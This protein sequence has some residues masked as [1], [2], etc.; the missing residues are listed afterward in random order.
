MLAVSLATFAG[1]GLLLASTGVFAIIA[2]SVSRRQREIGIR[3][4]LGA[5]PG[6]LEWLFLRASLRPASV[7]VAFGLFSAGALA[8]VLAK[9]LYGV[10]WWD[11]PTYLVTAALLLA[12]ASAAAYVPA[13]RAAAVNPV[14]ALRSE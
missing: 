12:T 3:A 2:S 9:L 13:H 7:G 10:E 6:S 11:P 8:R 4:A 1:L 14:E 5:T